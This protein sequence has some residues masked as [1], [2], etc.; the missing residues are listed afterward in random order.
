MFSE[1]AAASPHVKDH[2][3]NFLVNAYSRFFF[4]KGPIP[5]LMVGF[6]ELS[7]VVRYLKFDPQDKLAPI[8]TLVCC[9]MTCK[10]CTYISKM[11]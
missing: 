7:D 11:L 1:L 6:T 8:K 10:H 4:F 9:R 5:A 2:I 3:A